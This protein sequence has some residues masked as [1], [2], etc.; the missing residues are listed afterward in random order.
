PACNVKIATSGSAIVVA[1]LPNLL[2]VSPN[3]SSWKSRCQSRPVRV[4]GAGRCSVSSR[5]GV[6]P[7]CCC[8][9]DFVNPRHI[10]VAPYGCAI[11]LRQ[12][13]C[14]SVDDELNVFLP[15]EILD[16]WRTHR[17]GRASSKSAG[18]M[19]M[20]LPCGTPKHRKD[21]ALTHTSTRTPGRIPIHPTTAQRIR[22]TWS[23]GIA[24]PSPAAHP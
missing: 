2:T 23:G 11:K 18:V 24:H 4:R 5:M 22:R 12:H 6:A 1:A 3:H 8:A 14:E 17:A 10:D 15:Y 16:T 9:I 7:T 13:R 20:P 19:I 21:P